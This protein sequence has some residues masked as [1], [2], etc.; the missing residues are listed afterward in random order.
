M[1]LPVIYVCT[2]P[3]DSSDF[4]V[5]GT[6][7]MVLFQEKLH[8]QCSP[9]VWLHISWFCISFGYGKAALSVFDELDSEDTRGARGTRA[10]SLS[11]PLP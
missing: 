11:M 1:S 8:F 9:A 6:Y 3:V 7:I 10:R 2:S 5:Y 4:A